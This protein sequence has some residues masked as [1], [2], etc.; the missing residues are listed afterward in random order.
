[1]TERYYFDIRVAVESII[2]GEEISQINFVYKKKMTVFL[3]I[4]MKKKNSR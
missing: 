2:E 4:L 3:P 1:M